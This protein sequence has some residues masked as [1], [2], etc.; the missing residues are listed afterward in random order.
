M[1]SGFAGNELKKRGDSMA[2][3]GKVA[4]TGQEKRVVFFENNSW[5]H[6]TKELMD[7]MTVKY[8][9]KGASCI[10]QI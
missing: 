3:K 8:S 1:K 5:Y 6:R 4:K 7:D 2:D 9:K 10:I